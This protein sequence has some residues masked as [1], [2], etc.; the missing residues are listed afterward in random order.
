MQ[1]QLQLV[2]E[3]FSPHSFVVSIL[4]KTTTVESLALRLLKSYEDF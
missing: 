2:L 3:H 1:L 4:E